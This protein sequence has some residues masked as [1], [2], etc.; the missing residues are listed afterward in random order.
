MSDSRQ[1]KAKRAAAMQA[2]RLAWELAAEQDRQPWPS[3]PSYE[4][5]ADAL[6]RV[7]PPTTQVTQIQMQ[8]QQGPPA[9]DDP[10]RED[11]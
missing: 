6:E 3:R 5:E 10:D 8:A 4:A 2:R 11:K 7:V 9:N 1:I